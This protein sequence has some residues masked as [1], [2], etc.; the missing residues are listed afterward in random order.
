MLAWLFDVCDL[1]YD[2]SMSKILT[3]NKTE[4]LLVL[5]FVVAFGAFC[6]RGFGSRKNF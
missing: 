5:G 1:A 4:W 6:M 3:M 2:K